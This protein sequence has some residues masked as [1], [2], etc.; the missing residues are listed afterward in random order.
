MH[1]LLTMIG[2]AGIIVVGIFVIRFL[3]GKRYNSYEKYYPNPRFCCPRCGAEITQETAFCPECGYSLRQSQYPEGG[4][5]GENASSG[6][7]NGR[8]Q[9][10]LFPSRNS[11]PNRRRIL[12]KPVEKIQTDKIKFRAAAP[13]VLEK[14]K[15]STVKLIVY[16][17]EKKN[18]KQLA[19]EEAAILARQ[20]KQASSGIKSIERGENLLIWLQ[21]L[22]AE[23]DENEAVITWDGMYESYDFAVRVPE[24]FTNKQIIIKIRIFRGTEVKQDNILT[25]LK[26]ILDVE[27]SGT[28]DV[29]LEPCK[30][31]SAFL[32]Y[33]HKDRKEVI[34]LMRGFELGN[35]KVDWI[36]DCFVLRP[37][38]Y[39]EERLQKYILLA[40]WFYLFWSRNAAESKEVKK[41]IDFAIEHK[42]TDF[43]TPVPVGGNDSSP[44]PKA[45]ENKHFD[46]WKFKYANQL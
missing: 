7:E 3:F 12:V 13:A 15:W 45:L 40:D 6:R 10:N 21:S 43:I 35:K 4:T 23:F 16:N 9:S 25:D 28:Q 19:D 24:D 39:W 31:K 33:S 2:I 36:M 5:S 26:L 1:T 8:I 22:D 44:L 37:G 17:Y 34:T 46:D 11:A 38:D 14:G 42:G 20:V 41:E 18:M 27:A 29:Q 30:M 32:S